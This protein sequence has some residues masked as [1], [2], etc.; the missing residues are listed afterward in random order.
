MTT[1]SRCLSVRLSG[2]R[3]PRVIISD[4]RLEGMKTTRPEVAERAMGRL[5]GAPYDPAAVRLATQRLSQLGV[6]RRAEFA[7]LA[8]GGELRQGVL[9]WRVEEPR[10]NTFEG[11]VGVQGDAHVGGSSKALGPRA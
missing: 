1:L 9:R 10:F 2:A 6:F 5:R 4:V 7:G 8:G 11:A 3:G